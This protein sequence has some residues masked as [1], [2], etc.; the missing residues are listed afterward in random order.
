MTAA[1]QVLLTS[2]DEGQRQAGFALL[3]TGL[4]ESGSRKAE[5]VRVLEGV[6]REIERSARRDPEQDYFTIVG[7]P[8]APAWG[9]RYEG[10]H[11]AQNWTSVD[12]KVTATTPAFIGTNP[13]KVRDGPHRGLRVLPAEEDARA[14]R[15][16]RDGTTRHPHAGDEGGGAAHTGGIERR[17]SPSSVVVP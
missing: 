17:T 13:A 2:L 15:D 11:L 3:R 9:W 4:S 12:G 7:E 1:A 14:G 16:K 5:G 10:H 8:G 6:L